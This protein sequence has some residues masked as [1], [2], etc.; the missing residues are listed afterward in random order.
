LMI[1]AAAEGGETLAVLPAIAQVMDRFIARGHAHDDW[2]V[3]SKDAFTT[4]GST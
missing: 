4:P 1:E 3:I 2:T